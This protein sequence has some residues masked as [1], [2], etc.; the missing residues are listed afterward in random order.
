MNLLIQFLK[1][2]KIR[3]FLFLILLIII[4]NQSLI[5]SSIQKEV[6]SIQNKEEETL[7]QENIYILGPGDNLR[8]KVHDIK[9]LSGDFIILNDGRV[10]M[11]FIDEIDINGLSINQAKK[12]IEEIL[13]KEL[14]SPQVEIS[15]IKPRNIMV[16]VTGEVNK[17]GI[18]TFEST[19][20]DSF[21]TITKGIQMAGGLKPNSNLTNVLI[22]RRL[23]S[24]DDQ[25]NYKKA[26]IN[27]IDLILEGDQEKN[28]YL[29]DGDVITIKKQNSTKNR[30]YPALISNLS[31]ETINIVVSGE[32]LSPG[33]IKI[34]NGSTLN[35]AI[36]AAGGL[37]N[38]R[39]SKNALLVSMDN[40]G[41]LKKRNIKINLSN[42]TEGENNPVLANKDIIKVNRN[43]FTKATDNLGFVDKPIDSL[44]K[45]FTL[46]KL[47][48][49]N[50]D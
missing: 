15:I 33:R 3:Y 36:L 46:F 5:S 27:L 49:D 2:N 8:I 37:I 40:S 35:E 39:S 29:F 6:E 25:I 28:L 44:I 14:I 11:P 4:P 20:N 13:S 30:N 48:N 42:T 47:I 10:T 21:P 50:D 12:R 32:V 34:A 45:Y 43:S 23:P 7:L 38:N 1:F 18:Y 19:N 24:S 22:K 41:K 26:E 31:S 16:S 17:P 9:E